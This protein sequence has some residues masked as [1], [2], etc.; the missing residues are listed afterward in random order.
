MQQILP[1]HQFE[2]ASRHAWFRLKA[3][4]RQNIGVDKNF[5]A[6]DAA[7]K[8]RSGVLPRG[9]RIT[10][11]GRTDGAGMQ[12]LARMSGI[13]FA[14]AFGATY[15]DTPFRRV[16]HCPGDLAEW[17]AGW[18]EL[19]NLG[20]GEERIGDG[21]YRVIDYADYLLHRPALDKRTVLRFQQC[22]WLHRRYPDSFEAVAPRLREKFR[23]A[24]R[25]PSDEMRVAVHIRRGDVT[26]AKNASRF[27]PDAHILET[28]RCVGAL[29]RRTGRRFAV[30]VYSEGDPADFAP[31][32]NAGCGLHIDADPMWTMR[33]L[34]E[35]DV[36][37]MSKSSFAYVAAIL[38]RGLKIYEPTFNPPMS[39]WVRKRRGGGFDV[40]AAQA[41]LAETIATP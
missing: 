9:T 8:L 11:A 19:F 27:T 6:A 37:V 32:A 7:M 35:A 23:L 30:D 12:T 10:C 20:A 14:H 21:D 34:A 41:R 33:R 31:F 2:I 22:Y 16:H 29:A 4:I 36:L 3:L 24:P 25:A 39:R 18:E 28:L 38:N 17:A 5:F 15:V 26:A 13:N 40:R 1:R